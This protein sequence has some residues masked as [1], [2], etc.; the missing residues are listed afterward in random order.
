MNNNPSEAELRSQ[1]F[2]H[3]LVLETARVTEAAALAASSW[4]GMGDKNAVD[5]AGTTAM[6]EVLGSLNIRG[7]V[8]IGEGEMDEAPMLY[9]GEK[10]GQG[11]YEVDIAVDPVEGTTVTAKGLPNGIA[12]IALSEKGG[13]MHAPDCY[14]EKLVV[15]PP[16]ANKVSLDYSIAE[17]LRIIAESLERDVDDLLVTILDRERHADHIRQ[18]RE[19]GARVKLIGDGDVIAS[20]AVAVRG[21]G[22]HCLMGSGG[23][24]EGVLSAAAMKCLGGHI[25]G[26]FIAEDDA[27]RERFRQMG[28]EEGRIYKTHELAPGNEIVFSATGITSGDLL[29]GVRRF[30]GGARTHTLVMGHATRVVRFIDTVHLEDDGARVTVRI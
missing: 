1:K 23:A 14:M 30:G 7:T 25:Q 4:V 15:P 3:A 29:Y 16:A 9:I 17:N 27:Q 8:V 28:V 18:I 5:G 2:E 22:V 13:L 12:V 10:L 11:E 19:A 21:S 6:R 24:P 26:K 20:L